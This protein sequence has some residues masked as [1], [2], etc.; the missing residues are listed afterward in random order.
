MTRKRR[1]ATIRTSQYAVILVIVVLLALV[2]K[3]GD[4]RRQFLDW[5]VMGQIL[6][7][8][9]KT[10]LVNTLVY[11]LTSFIFGLLLGL[12][13]ALMRLSQVRLYRW[14][15]TVYV[16][17][18]RGLPTLLVLYLLNFAIPTLFG[19]NNKFLTNFYV[20]VTIGLGS[21]AAAY[22]SET[23]RA[24]IQAVPKGQMEAARTLGMPNG[25]A[26]M[27]IVLPQAF[28]IIIPPLTNEIIL[29]IKDSSLVYALGLAAAQLELTGLSQ[30]AASGGITGID[31]SSSPLVLAG[32]AYLVI[33]L[34][35]S[36]AVRYLEI[37]QAKRR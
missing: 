36:Q 22:M 31:A 2:G 13:I 24:G 23:I 37:R 14:I 21:V 3:W 19:S 34:P 33:T 5:H 29:L 30:T 7:R 4:F 26:M 28:R 27:S 1:T 10:G 11:T 18:F 15:A 17:L 25:R 20:L 9:I 35:L 32:L 8:I 6:P 16:E 12:I